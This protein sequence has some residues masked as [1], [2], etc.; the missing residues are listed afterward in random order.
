[1]IDSE[2]VYAIDRWCSLL[3]RE[4][5][6]K[7]NLEKWVQDK[8]IRCQGDK[9]TYPCEVIALIIGEM[10]SFLQGHGCATANRGNKE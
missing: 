8:I 7:V 3:V 9:L 6:D 5:R 2:L 1:M 10:Q 4:D